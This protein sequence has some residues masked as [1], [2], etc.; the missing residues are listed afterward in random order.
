MLRVISVAPAE[1]LHR[2]VPSMVE[3]GYG[4]IVNVASLA[5]LVDA[6]AGATYGAA[7]TFLVSLSTSLH[8]ELQPLGV[9]VTAVCPGLVRTGFHD[10]PELRATVAAAPGWMWTPADRVAAEG[11]A[12]VMR[13]TPTVVNGRM[14]RLL[15]TTLR[16]VPRRL[17][18]GAA[19]QAARVARLRRRSAP[20]RP[21]DVA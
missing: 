2:L 15:I 12:A 6:G 18:T 1:L 11:F 19:R 20:P 14:N 3:R 8:R 17:L 13:G 4:R 21:A 5:G 9:H 16:L 10:R 7:K